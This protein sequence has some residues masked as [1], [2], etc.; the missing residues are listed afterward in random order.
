MYRKIVILFFLILAFAGGLIA[1][2]AAF[3]KALT[4]T[5]PYI[6][7]AA[8]IG[9]FDKIKEY[10]NI[11]LIQEGPDVKNFESFDGQKKLAEERGLGLYMNIDPLVGIDRSKALGNFGNPS[12]RA[13]FK[14][15]VRQI[16]RRYHP[17]YLGI[18]SEVNIYYDANP[19]RFEDFVS[20]Y[21]ESYEA[22]KA[23]DPN[24]KVFTTFQYE[25][26]QNLFRSN[27]RGLH[28]DLINKFPQD[29]I[30]I[31]AHPSGLFQTPAHMPDDYYSQI[32]KY[33]DLPLV[34]AESSWPAENN[35]EGTWHGSPENE[36][37]FIRRTREL[38]KD[39][40]LKLWV[41][42]FVYNQFPA[43]YIFCK[44]EKG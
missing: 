29:Y 10:G 28:W 42:W 18:G 9:T 33:S 22:A 36:A 26:L 32:R 34:I 35:P 37:A 13:F 31:S 12:Y 16:V 25:I 39:M 38:T 8:F 44:S 11:V 24:V 4:A 19:K 5:P 27:K 7:E 1:E 20:L 23:E 3:D 14:D 43:F 17:K 6:T 30:A 15:Y 41:W 40:N 21:K 2:E